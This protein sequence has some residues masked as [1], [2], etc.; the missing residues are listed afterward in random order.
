MDKTKTKKVWNVV[1]SIIVG[2][3]LVAAV[4]AL[5]VAIGY[6]AQ[7]QTLTVGGSQ[8]RL[9]LTGSMEGSEEDSIRTNSVITVKTV[10]EDAEQAR[11]FMDSLEVGDVITFYDTSLG[12]SALVV[13]HRIVGITDNGNGGVS[14]TTK[15]DANDSPDPS[16]VDEGDVIGVV[17]GSNYPLGA[18]LTFLTSATGIVVC[19]II[20]AAII[21]IYEIFRIAFLVRK[22]KKDKRKSELDEK[23]Q[24]I[25]RLRRELEEMKKRGEDND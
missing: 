1:S 21:M 16:P 2:V 15:G 20:P 6:R 14:F 25:E 22:D 17:T 12:A 5:G 3:V 11:E 19:L 24:E 10:P 8:L 23:E 4:C 18:F 13:T 9:V 7:G